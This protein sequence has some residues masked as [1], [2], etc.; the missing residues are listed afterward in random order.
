MPVFVVVV[1]FGG[2]WLGWVGCFYFVCLFCFFVV[3]SFC[4]AF[5]A[6]SKRNP[7]N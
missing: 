7:D 3:A 5:P 6:D 2:G 1:V 4:F